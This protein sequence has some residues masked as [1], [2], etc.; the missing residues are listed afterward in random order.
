ASEAAMNASGWELRDGGNLAAIKRGEIVADLSMNSYSPTRFAEFAYTIDVATDQLSLFQAVNST[1]DEVWTPYQFFL[2][3]SPSALVLIFAVAIL[4]NAVT[5]ANQRI[6]SS[7]GLICGSLASAIFSF[8]IMVIIFMHAAVFKGN[9][10]VDAA[11]S[12]FSWDELMSKLHAGSVQYIESVEN[13]EAFL[14]AEMLGQ[15]KPIRVPSTQDAIF[16]ICKNPGKAVAALY[17]MQVLHATDAGII[18]ASCS[19]HR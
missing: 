2:V 5:A 14:Y 9:M 1:S 13:F 16:E 6:R 11:S 15:N 7:L 12:L 4:M 3:F 10:I 18:L 17:N 8:C 19:I